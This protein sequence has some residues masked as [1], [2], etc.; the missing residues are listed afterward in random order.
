MLLRSFNS[1]FISSLLAFVS[2]ASVMTFT[3]AGTAS[4]DPLVGSGTIA[5]DAEPT[6]GGINTS[7]SIGTIQNCVSIPAGGSATI[8]V[9]VDSIP[10]VVGPSGGLAGFAFNITYPSAGAGALNVTARPTPLAIGDSLLTVNPTSVIASFSDAV[11]DSDGDMRI[12]ELD[13]DSAYESGL[14]RLYSITVTSVGPAGVGIL[15]LTDTTAGNGDTVPDLYSSDLTT[16]SPTTVGDALVYV[17]SPCPPPTIY[18]GYC[19]VGQSTGVSWTWKYGFFNGSVSVAAGGTAIQI[20]S[21]WV[22]SLEFEF[23]AGFFASQLP[24]PNEHC[25]KITPGGQTLIVNN[26]CAVT[27]SGCSFN[28]MVFLMSPVGGIAELRVSDVGRQTVDNSSAPA[29]S[30]PSGALGGALAFGAAAMAT[31]LWFARKRWSR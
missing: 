9:V 8:E 13:S 6:V 19:I 14:G 20:A 15:D 22:D 18:Q 25:F 23:F 21:A 28:P 17:G 30:F 5:I 12:V 4:A 27:T 31:G 10:A 26:T 7:T 1:V 3:G 11:T 24:A 2:V 29:S 16:Y